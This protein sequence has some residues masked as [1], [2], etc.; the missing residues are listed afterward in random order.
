LTHP[1]YRVDIDGLRAVAVLSVVGFHAFPKLTNGGFIGVDIFFVVS[2]FLTSTI[3][4]GNLD[5]DNFSFVEFYS[6]RIRRIFPGLIVVLIAAFTA[7][8]FLLLADEY[9]QFCSHLA[10]GAGFISNLILWNESDYFDNAAETK[11]L[12]H[13]WSLGIEEQFYIIWPLLPWAG[14]K[15]SSICL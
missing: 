11:P 12:L 1:K 4:F 5:K 6:R 9:K 14:W 10:G 7:G 2:E 3:L 15:E 8:W 13:L